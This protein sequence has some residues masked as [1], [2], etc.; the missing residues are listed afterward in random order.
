M[1]KTRPTW[2]SVVPALLLALAL[3]PFLLWLR[4]SLAFG[5]TFVSLYPL[6]MGALFSALAGGFLAARKPRV[7]PLCAAPNHIGGAVEAGHRI[8]E[9][10]CGF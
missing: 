7:V 10:Y 5:T 2:Q 8:V 3:P 9:I 4:I 6:L 1:T